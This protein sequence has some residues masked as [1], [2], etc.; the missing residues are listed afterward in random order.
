MG[1]PRAQ[2]EATAAFVTARGWTHVGHYEDLGAS[3]FDPRAPRPGL[4]AVLSVVRRREAD[5]VV[6]YKLDRLTRQG[7]AEAVK[8]VTEMSNHDASLASVL[9]PFFDT[10]TPMGRGIFGIFA[11]L[12]EQESENI[13]QRT[14]ATK[15]VLRRA[16]S[17]AGGPRPFGYAT[18]KET[19]AG[20]T[21]TVLRPEPA[22][23]AVVAQVVARVLAGKSVSGEAHRLNVEGIPTARGAEW[24]TSTLS[25]LLHSPTIAGYLVERSY[26]RPV[27]KGKQTGPYDLLIV[28]DDTGTPVAA[29]E[30]LVAPADWHRLQETLAARSRGRGPRPRPT[31]L[32]GF[33]LLRCTSCGSRMAGDRRLDGR[34]VYRCALHRRGS[35]KCIGA[36]VAMAQADDYVTEAV[37]SRLRDLDPTNPADLRLLRAVA[38][39]YSVREM[40]PEKEAAERAARAVIADAES[41]LQQLDD[42]RTAGAFAGAT[43]TDRYRRQAAALTERAEAARQA[44][45]TLPLPSSGDDM[46]DLLEVLSALRYDGLD[47]RDPDSP[48]ARWSNDERREFLSLFLSSVTVRKSARHAGGDRHVWRGYERMTLVWA[49]DD[50]PF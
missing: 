21:V 13:S 12:A 33:D 3:G 18:A 17:F 34:G 44:L 24:S 42:D 19:R 32:G 27:T 15:G 2:Q 30:P 31:L 25:R 48:W 14:R 47:H 35:T 7:V 20:L 46:D 23:A 39:R 9:E 28:R 11:A 38:A 10:S 16:G 6:V 50:A 1:S 8:L 43:G 41:A 4:E 36:A 29:W 45:A 26:D 5:L 49:G 40:D 22:E 37:W